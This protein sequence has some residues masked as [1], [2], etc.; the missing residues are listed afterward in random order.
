MKKL[1]VLGFVLFCLAANM[2]LPAQSQPGVKKILVAYFTMPESGGADAVSGASRLIVDGKVT[3]NVQSA[4]VHIQR[5]VGGDL[6]IIQT[7]QAYPTVHN[8][9]L[10]YAKKEQEAN[11][12][13]RLSAQ[14]AD[15]EEY[16]TTS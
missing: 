13:P 4:A 6:F 9:L 5:A 2:E 1:F 8:E 12:R 15:M 11:T 7:V 3:G 10:E 14:I 16:D